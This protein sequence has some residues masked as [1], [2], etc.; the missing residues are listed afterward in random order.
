MRKRKLRRMSMPRSEW[1]D[2]GVELDAVE[3]ALGVLD[4][5]ALGVLGRGDG[6]EAA[7]EAGDL[8]AVGVPDAERGLQPLQELRALAEGKHAVSVFAVR[9]AGDVAAEHLAHELDAVA[10]A[11]DREAHLEDAGMRVRRA[12]RLHAV[13]AAGE[14]DAH[15][16]V[17][18]EGLGRD[19]EGIDARVDVALTDAA[20]DDLGQLRTEIEDGD[21]LGGH[22]EGKVSGGSELEANIVP[23]AAGADGF[24]AAAGPDIGQ[25]AADA[26]KGGIDA[27]VIREGARRD[28][29]TM[30]A[31][32]TG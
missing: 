15:D 4:D 26:G 13:G 7:R 29:H 6:L 16:A 19:A 17:G 25:A 24:L 22:D 11:E 3:A 21:G 12:L 2:L 5:G 32:R 27:A 20:R 10:D 14:D 1:R 28:G 18:A 30:P 23:S 31:A 9:A 8:V